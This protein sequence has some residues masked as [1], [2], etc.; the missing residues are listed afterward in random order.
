MYIQIFRPFKWLR[1]SSYAGA[2]ITV[3]FY[4]SILVATLT[5]TV[6]SPGQTLAEHQQTP[7]E[8]KATQ[9]TIPVGSVGLAIDVFIL[10]LPIVGVSKLQL[11]LRRKIGV[12][13]VFL[14]GLMYV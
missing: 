10:I 1:Y 4:F 5:F 8:A 6:P 7:R 13:A 3:L 2:I 14:T 9:V 12:M 11:P